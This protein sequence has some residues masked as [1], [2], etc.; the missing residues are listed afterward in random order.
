MALFPC[1]VNG[2]R[3]SGAQQTIY[4]AVVNKADAS[5]RRLRLC[6]SHFE[7]LLD[8]LEVTC[9]HAQADWNSTG[10]TRCAL[11]AEDVEDSDYQ[12]FAT[13]YAKGA[14]RADYWAPIHQG[15]VA[16]Q[17]EDW[18]LPVGIDF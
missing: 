11:C 5:R 1:D 17:L 2:H 13:V 12:F 7:A 3:Y 14:E 18:L 15:C 10:L 6:P 9:N 16:G 8:H 4:P